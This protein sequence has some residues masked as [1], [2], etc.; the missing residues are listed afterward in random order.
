MTHAI[1]VDTAEADSTAAN[2]LTDTTISCPVCQSTDVSLVLEI[3]GVPVLCNVHYDDAAAARSAPRGTIRLSFCQRCCH[4]FNAVFNERLLHYD[5]RYDNALHFSRTFR[6]YEEDLANRLASQYQLDGKTVIDIGSGDGHFLRLIC[7]IVGARGI[8]VDPSYSVRVDTGDDDDNVRFIPDLFSEQHG[9][10]Q[11]ELVCC[12]HTL[13]HVASPREFVTLARQAMMPAAKSAAYFEVPNALYTLEAGGIW[14]LIYEHPSF[15]TPNSLRHLFRTSEFDVIELH[16]AF[17]RQY[18]GLV[19]EGATDLPTNTHTDER[20]REQ[21]SVI[22]AAFAEQY[23]R[24]VADWQEMLAAFASPLQRVVVWGA[25]SKGIMFL[26]TLD[27]D[28]A[29]EHVVDVNPRKHG[30]HIAGSGQLIVSPSRLAALQPTTVILMNDIYRREVEE[31][32]AALDVR[33]RV[34][35]A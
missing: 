8:G 34:L 11:A 18:L 3:P 23:R 15:F 17:G 9:G 22:V 19:A 5:D 7:R 29:V 32:L 30:K 24:K 2:T 1:D 31:A 33:A 25:G 16:E 4:L 13:E 26:N 28:R 14:D 6:E 27:T 21:L 35:T 12:R 20:D 10:Q